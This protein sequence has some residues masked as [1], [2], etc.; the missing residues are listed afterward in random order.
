MQLFSEFS[1][2]RHTQTE[3]EGLGRKNGGVCMCDGEAEERGQLRVFLRW[4]WWYRWGK[5]LFLGTLNE[6]Q[7]NVLPPVLGKTSACHMQTRCWGPGAPA[8]GYEPRGGVGASAAL[9]W[10]GRPHCGRG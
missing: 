3:K 10:V 9:P 2:A 5:Q 4:W 1:K 6:Q 7:K 8:G